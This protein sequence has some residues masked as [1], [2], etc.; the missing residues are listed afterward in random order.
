MGSLINIKGICVNPFCHSACETSRKVAE[1]S[2]KV[3]WFLGSKYY[4]Q[5]TEPRNSSPL[6]R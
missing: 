3:S 2:G 4:K 6:Y 1:T 5:C